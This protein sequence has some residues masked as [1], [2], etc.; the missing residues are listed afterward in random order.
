MASKSSGAYE[1]LRNSGVI[2]LPSGRTLRD[3][4]HFAPVSVG[5]SISTDKQLVDL[6]NKNSES[7]GKY[8]SILIDEMYV[9]EGLV[10]DKHCG[11]ITV[12]VDLGE[13]NNYFSDLE[14][15][16]SEGGRKYR[17]IA[18]TL[19]VFM[20]RGLV[21]NYTFPY[22]LYPAS[23]HKGCDLFP[24]LWKIIERLT[25]NKFRVLAV[26]CDGASCNRKL[27]KLH[28]TKK[29]LVYKIMNDYV[30]D[31]QWIYFISELSCKFKAK[32]MGMC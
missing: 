27:F 7:L 22:A 4:R 3:Y 6:A 15:I 25:R 19:V 17:P 30:Q 10:F 31:E 23:S 24:P 16:V 29:A 14:N 5:L 2:H 11:R 1:M 21:T 9:K 20:V 8:V 12:F 26:T 28:S 18:K 13:V 32:F